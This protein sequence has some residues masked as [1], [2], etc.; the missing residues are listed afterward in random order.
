MIARRVSDRLCKVVPLLGSDKPGEVV[1][2]AAAIGRTLSAAGLSWHDL[3]TVLQGG[4]VV[5]PSVDSAKTSPAPRPQPQ[6][7]SVGPTAPTWSRLRP[8]DRL[9]WIDLLVREHVGAPG[10]ARRLARLR[11][12]MHASSA[13]VGAD[14]RAFFNKT[15]KVAWRYGYRLEPTP[16]AA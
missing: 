8:A 4:F 11:A 3:V 16:K 1:A 7:D 10:D 15:M 14:S 12:F 13:D 6:A 5:L 2:A 9:R